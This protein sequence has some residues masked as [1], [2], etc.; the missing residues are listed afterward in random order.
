MAYSPKTPIVSEFKLKE[1]MCEIGRRIW[2]KGFCA[3]NEGNHSFR[4]ADHEHLTSSERRRHHR[5]MDDRAN[6][7]HENSFRTGRARI[8]PACGYSFGDCLS[9]IVADVLVRCVG[10]LQPRPREDPV[11]IGMGQLGTVA[12]RL[13]DTARARRSLAEQR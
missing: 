7:R 6:R 2:L 13:A 10:V 3:G 12:A 8:E 1:E 5:A 9:V 11:Q 4:I